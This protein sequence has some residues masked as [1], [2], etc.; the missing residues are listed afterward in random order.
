VPGDR[1]VAVVKYGCEG[2]N[3]QGRTNLFDEILTKVATNAAVR[4][5]DKFFLT[6]Y[7]LGVLD[8]LFINVNLGHVVHKNC[9][10]FRFKNGDNVRLRQVRLMI[11][12]TA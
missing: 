10:P 6:L 7:Q 9:T 2:P 5:L 3:L 12:N 8:Y 4:Q 11:R 1:P